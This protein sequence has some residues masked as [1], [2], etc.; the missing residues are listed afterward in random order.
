MW[1][2]GGAHRKTTSS[3]RHDADG[4]SRSGDTVKPM[5]VAAAFCTVLLGLASI[6]FRS[7]LEAGNRWIWNSTIGDQ[8]KLPWL[9]TSRAYVVA[10]VVVM[11]VG[12]ALGLERSPKPNTPRSETADSGSR[13]TVLDSTDRYVHP[14]HPAPERGFR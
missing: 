8:A 9:M 14:R 5:V 7:R 11:A 2:S 10:G 13:A 6:L 4:V 12:I 1:L 3:P